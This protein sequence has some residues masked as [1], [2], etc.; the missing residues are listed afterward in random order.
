MCVCVCLWWGWWDGNLSTIYLSLCW[1]SLLLVIYLRPYMLWHWSCVALAI[2]LSIY[3]SIYLFCMYL[4]LPWRYYES[5]LSIHPRLS[6]SLS[7]CIYSC[8]YLWDGY[9]IH[10]FYLSI[11]CSIYFWHILVVFDSSISLSINLSL[12]LS[13][14]SAYILA[15]PVSTMV[16]LS[17]DLSVCLSIYL[18]RPLPSPV[19]SW[20][21]LIH[22]PI[23]LLWEDSE[24][25][26][27]I[28]HMSSWLCNMRWSTSLHLILES[29]HL[30]PLS[31]L[32]LFWGTVYPSIHLCIYLFINPYLWEAICR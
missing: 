29:I 12:C 20:S 8:F 17:I 23:Y 19:N 11:S 6:L 32:G 28:D 30:H 7:L 14:I 27:S 25:N 3:P 26:L 4:H 24:S 21:T 5:S 13:L 9:W 18:S 16:A 10:Q 22:L 15:Q 1:G 2:C 31:A